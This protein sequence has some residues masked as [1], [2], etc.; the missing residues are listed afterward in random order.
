[1]H[2][3]SLPGKSGI[4]EIGTSAFRFIDWLNQS[5]L[6]V[7]QF[8]PTGP[9]G[10]GNSPYQP[11]S[12]FA[13]NP[14]FIDL[15]VLRELDLLASSELETYPR[16]PADH[17]EYA[18]LIPLKLDYVNRAARRFRT[19]ASEDLEEAFERFS[20]LNNDRWLHDFA[21]FSVIR[22][23]HDR[24]PWTD[25][26]RSFALRDP[27]ALEAFEELARLEVECVKVVQFLFHLQWNE[28]RR[29]ASERGVTLFG[30]V[31]IYMALD[32]AEAWARPDLL[33]LDETGLPTS[34]AGVPPDYFSAEGQNWG[35]PL[36]RWDRHEAEGFSWWLTRLEHAFGLMDLVR[37]DHF[38]GFEAY[39]AIPA[40]AESASE[41]EWRPGPREK[42]FDTVAE[43]LGPVP[44]VAE[45]LGLITEEVRALRRAYHW[46]G[47]QVLQFLVDQEDFEID[48]LTNDCV[49]YTGTHD[50]D[51][52]VGWFRGSEGK[53]TGIELDTLQ[54]RILANTSG[55]PDA[56]HHDMIELAFMSRAPIAIAPMQ[57]FLGLDSSA[58][59]NTP[60]SKSGNWQWRL[61]EEQ[62]QT[63][64]L[65]YVERLVCDSGRSPL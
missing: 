6:S 23:H 1:M 61:R 22:D 54:Q 63:E 26:H 8:L 20:S 46:P 53:L 44:I 49:C 51:T 4:G 42:L 36:Y 39:W 55:R 24:A 47:M 28:L 31:P 25:W 32:C 3:S 7:W 30:D 34:V 18:R 40:G 48:V 2:I 58:R 35:S 45:D 52:T 13:G 9:T 15:E 27:A 62:L 64:A 14:L 37:L 41:G 38:R 59:M 65:A 57:D 56:I 16:L 33:E 43:V 50:N 11:L 10:Y 17:V 60:G 19:A 21:L 5:G 12:L 29:Y